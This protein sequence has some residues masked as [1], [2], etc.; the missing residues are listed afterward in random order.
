MD[1]RALLGVVQRAEQ[2]RSLV[3]EIEAGGEPVLDVPPEARAYLAAS[4]LDNVE[5][6]ALLVTAGAETARDWFEQLKAWFGESREVHLFRVPDPL[7]YERIHWT[8]DTIQQRLKALTALIRSEKA[9]VIAPARALASLTLPAREL[10]LATRKLRKGQMVAQEELLRKWFSIGYRLVPVVETPGTVARRGGILDVWP[11]NLDLPVRVEFF[12]DEIDSLRSFDPETQRTL[13]KLEEVVIGPGSEALPKFAENALARLRELDFSSCHPPAKAEFDRDMEKLA[14]GQGFEGI[15]YYIPFLYKSPGSILDALQPSALVLLEER[16]SVLSALKT[17]E[18]QATQ[19][20]RE[21]I[22]GGELPEGWPKAFGTPEEVEAKLSTRQKLW[23]G[24]ST[25]EKA[26]HPIGSVFWRAPLYNSQLDDLIADLTEWCRQNSIAVLI[27][28]QTPR[29][30][31]LLKGEGIRADVYEDGR[32]AALPERGSISLVQGSISQGFA[33]R[34]SE[35][36]PFDLV[37]L[38]DEEIFGWKRPRRRRPRPRAQAQME[39]I[40]AELKPGDYVVHMDHGIGVYKGLVRLDIGR[41]EQEYLLLEYAHGDKLYVP[42]QQVN[43]LSKYIGPTDQPPELHRLHSGRWAQTKKQVKKAVADVARELLETYAA[44]EMAEGFPFSPDTEWQAEMEAA[45]PFQETED[46][47]RAIQEV[48]QDMEKPRP[49]DRLVCGDAG[50]GKTEV[51]VRAAFKAV[52]DGKQV[53][54]LAPTT[55]LAQ[56]HFYTIKKRVEPFPINVAMLTRLQTRSQQKKVVE[57]LRSGKI[58]IVVGTHRLLSKDVGFKDLGLV[59]VDEEQRFGVMHKEKLKKLRHQVDVLTLTAT[60]IP[61]T[62]YLAMA[63]VRDISLI[64]T[65]PSDRSS[66][67]TFVGEFSESLIRKAILRELERDGQVYFVHNRVESIE[68]V[69]KMVQRLV[70]QA[71]VAVAHG[72]MP[73]RQLANVMLAFAKGDIDVLVCTTIIENGLDVPNANT[74]I[75]NHAHRFGLSQL[76]Q[77]RGRVGR[78]PA[79]G[80]AYLLYPRGYRLPRKVAER[81]E[82]LERTTQPGT[83]FQIAMRDL[84]SR[85]AG[86]ILGTKQHGHMAAVGLD[87]YTKLLAQAI[88]E[89]REQRESGL[90]LNPGTMSLADSLESKLSPDLPL[91]ASIPVDYVPEEDLRLRLYRQLSS[92]T[93]FEDLD[94]FEKMLRDRFGKLPDGTRNLLYLVRVKILAEKAK[95]N[96]IGQEG[97]Q[98]VVK[99]DGKMPDELP[100]GVQARFGKIMIPLDEDGKWKHTLMKTLKALNRPYEENYHVT[101]SMPTTNSKS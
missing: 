14:S 18:H 15:E 92:C 82:I 13:E 54:I 52:M 35:K 49:M 36:H 97:E 71:V 47:L 26:S 21:M 88:K 43:R 67:K 6:P 51:A 44:R 70:P 22:R 50:Y 84:E 99:S 45:F 11:P 79:R 29:M 38:T 58:D 2:F 96:F 81:L 30:A 89:L 74:I 73:E 69:A 72:Q 28:R 37:I 24:R 65:P 19:V 1:L 94:E 41:G 3:E 4:L 32:M 83:G 39:S 17:L 76:Y 61:R 90:K 100:K 57:G 56:Q 87:M 60:P 98:I 53:A 62:L 64:A 68:A 101:I 23:L 93:T 66:I 46:Q 7:P 80:Y 10:K 27:T 12:G 8:P 95:V 75:V 63:G 85:G 20:Q 16:E 42:V 31:E 78:G 91:N 86:E 77:L 40:F 5:R 48:K 25:G 55:V 34:Q 59:I 9:I 33:L